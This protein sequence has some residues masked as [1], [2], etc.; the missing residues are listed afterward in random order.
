MMLPKQ[1][2]NVCSCLQE[3]VASTKRLRLLVSCDSGQV[4]AACG[5]CVYAKQT[6]GVNPQDL[7][8]SHIN[9]CL[10]FFAAAAIADSDAHSGG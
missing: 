2:Q 5:D 10:D 9:D 1:L 6:F 4:L 8:H 7:A 3:A